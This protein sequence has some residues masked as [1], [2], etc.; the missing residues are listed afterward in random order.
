VVLHQLMEILPYAVSFSLPV[1]LLGVLVLRLMRN[2]SIAASTTALV[3]L[4][5]LAVIAGFAGTSGF[6]YSPL[7]VDTLLLCG[8]VAA[9][10]VPTAVL[11]G[12]AQARRTVWEKEAIGRER[13]AEASRRQLIAWI[14]HDLRTPLAGIRAMTEALEDGVVRDPA[15]VADYLRRVRRESDRL[16]G[17]VDDLF[18]LSR[19]TAGALRLT[20]SAVPLAAVVGDALGSELA[21]AA[22]HG[23]TLRAEPGRWPVVL[24][25]D[26]ELA[27]VV[28]NLISNAVRHTPPDGSV[29]VAAGVGDGGDPGQAWLRVDD[30]C[31]GIPEPDLSKVFDVAFRG[32]AARTPPDGAAGSRAEATGAAPRGARIGSPPGA[33]LGL[34]IA[35]GLVEAHRGTIA[36]RNHGPG[37][38]FEI[39]LPA[40]ATGGVPSTTGGPVIASVAA[41]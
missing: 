17:M 7:L 34:A 15:D 30:C 21:T 1:A 6:M 36:V 31:G 4:P 37:C 24:G 9:V 12:R 8:V 13:A 16:A 14:S 27:R 32:V 40:V 2:R 23:I 22:R 39:R 33:G 5:L 19:I 18:E 10:V 25:S 38:R 26:P 41:V 11:M 35:R 3:V 28:R 20:M 29:V